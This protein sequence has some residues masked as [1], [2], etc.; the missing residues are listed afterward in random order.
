MN[1]FM[2]ERHGKPFLVQLLHK[3]IWFSDTKVHSSVTQIVFIKNFQVTIDMDVDLNFVT[4]RNLLLGHPNKSTLSRY[5][6]VKTSITTQYRMLHTFITYI[7][8]ALHCR[9]LPA[10]LITKAPLVG[11]SGCG[12]LN[13]SFSYMLEMLN[14]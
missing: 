6:N 14:N 10:S 8:P 4:S 9:I 13:N 5:R 11:Y 12:V 3:K 2:T 1:N 7:W